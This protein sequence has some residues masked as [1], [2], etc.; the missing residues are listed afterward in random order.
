M[1]LYNCKIHFKLLCR[2]E[3]YNFI[4]TSH[5]NG[6][7]TNSNHFFR[8]TDRS[9]LGNAL[10]N[11]RQDDC[12]SNISRVLPHF[13]K[14]DLRWWI[15]GNGNS[16][17][18]F[19]ISASGSHILLSLSNSPGEEGLYSLWATEFGWWIDRIESL[20]PFEF[21]SS[22]ETGSAYFE[23]PI[24]F[25]ELL[26]PVLLCWFAIRLL[27]SAAFS[28]GFRYQDCF[29]YAWMCAFYTAV[30]SIRCGICILYYNTVAFFISCLN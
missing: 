12:P 18:P 28:F 11:L 3:T 25:R 15:D 24:L 16:L 29:M 2:F 30:L 22:K 13:L 7:K 19:E 14:P 27:V 17:A 6:F 10:F 21:S 20:A 23:E 8:P 26:F 5:L 4:N 9:S 1:F